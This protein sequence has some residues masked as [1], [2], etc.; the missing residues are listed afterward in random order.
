MSR[1][2]SAGA[3]GSRGL[4]LGRDDHGETR[5]LV[6]H[7]DLGAQLVEAE[8]LDE[9]GCLVS[10]RVEQEAVVTPKHQKIEQD[11]A[12]RRQQRG[13]AGLA[14][15]AFFDVV[16]DQP[17]QEA[18]RVRSFDPR[19][20]AVIKKRFGHKQISQSPNNSR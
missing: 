14:D 15:G 10:G 4:A 9:L 18:R 13:V 1:R 7:A 8:P 20:A 12:L 11:L 19:H 6:A 16:G 3:R 5:A 2:P 17:L